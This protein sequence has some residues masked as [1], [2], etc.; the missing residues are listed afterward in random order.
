MKKH[1][2]ANRAGKE[3]SYTN[4]FLLCVP[5]AATEAEINPNNA[6]NIHRPAQ[7]PTIA[8]SVRDAAPLLLL[9][10]HTLS[11][12]LLLLLLGLVSLLDLTTRSTVDSG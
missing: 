11:L 10:P 2:S 12:L 9:A 3:G 5:S 6:T 1:T 4:S 8:Q 7:P